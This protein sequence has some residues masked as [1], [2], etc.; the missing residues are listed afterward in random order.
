MRWLYFDPAKICLI[1]LAF[2]ASGKAMVPHE[3]Q[4][5]MA[6]SEYGPAPTLEFPEPRQA[7]EV[8]WQK[9]FYCQGLVAVSWSGGT[10]R[11]V[12]SFCFLM[13]CTATFGV[14]CQRFIQNLVCL[15]TEEHV[16]PALVGPST[17][18]IRSRIAKPAIS[19][20][21]FSRA[22]RLQESMD[23]Y[24]KVCSI[25]PDLKNMISNIW[26][27]PNNWLVSP[28]PVVDIGWSSCS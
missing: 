5:M 15:C 3:R 22:L 16:V 27:C 20:N 10:W 12:L 9:R 26:V 28:N 23:L 18:R 2:A 24:T 25:L 14:R 17:G 4:S 1:W 19:A 11:L 13:T 8:A 21:F 6:E 7:V